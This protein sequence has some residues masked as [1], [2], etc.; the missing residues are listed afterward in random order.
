[1]PLAIEPCGGFGAE[2]FGGIAGGGLQG[3]HRGEAGLDEI[4]ELVVEAEA[5]EDEDRGSGVGA[6]EEWNAGAVHVGDHFQ[7][8]RE[9]F[10]AELERI[11]LQVGNHFVVEALPGDIAPVGGDVF[12]ERIVGEIALIE[13]RAAALPGE[14]WALP[15]LRFGEQREQARCIFSDRWW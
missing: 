6:G 8:A 4:G 13:K 14:R 12:A 5:G 15:G 9:I 10:F 2:K 3:F 7:I 1:M 11:V